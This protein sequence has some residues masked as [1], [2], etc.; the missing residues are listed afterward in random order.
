M[1]VILSEAKEPKLFGNT[2]TVAFPTFGPFALLRVTTYRLT[3][4]PHAV[5]TPTP[6]PAAESDPCAPPATARTS[7]APGSA[8]G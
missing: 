5:S 6:P 1:G 8:S 7:A 3:A 4:L 2:S